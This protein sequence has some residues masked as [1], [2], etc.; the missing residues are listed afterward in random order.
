[1][2]GIAGVVRIVRR[3]E[4]LAGRPSEE[5]I[6]DAWLDAL[7]AGIAWRGPDG[8]GRFRDRAVRSDGSEVH[9]GLV[10]RRLSII[11][12]EGGAQPM[13]VER[14]GESA[15][16]TLVFNGCV[17][18][19]G[20]LRELLETAG[21]AFETSHSDTE[22]LAR[23]MLWYVEGSGTWKEFG[24]RGP[25][26]NGMFAA[27]LWSRRAT[28]VW[29]WRDPFGEKPLFARELGG[30]ATAFA[31]TAGAL[32]CLPKLCDP[33]PGL[34]GE[35]EKLDRRRSAATWLRFGFDAW[36]TP[37][38]GVRSVGSDESETLGSWLAS[39]PEDPSAAA[40][41]LAA[42]GWW[43]V[44]FV[45]FPV[46]W[47]VL[48]V[49][50]CWREA[51]AARGT[52]RS[53]RE[54]S[55]LTEVGA[56]LSRAVERRLEADVPIGCL[57]SGGVDSSLIASYAREHLGEL[58]TVTVRMPD[59]RYDES[60][61][62]RAVAEQI[63]SDHHEIEASADAAT[64]LVDLI[65]KLGLPLGDSSLLPTYWACRGARSVVKAALSG[66]GGDELFWGYDRYRAA[67]LFN[68][69]T[70]LAAR[71][72]PRAVRERGVDDP[73]AASTRRAR[74]LEAA[75]HEGYLDLVSIF[76]TPMLRG[77]TGHRGGWRGRSWI[78]PRDGDSERPRSR[79]QARGWDLRHYLPGDLLLKTDTASLAA[80]LELRAPMLDPDL[81]AWAIEQPRRLLLLGGEPKG[82]LRALARQRLPASV[83]DRPKQGFAI[84]VG[85]WFRTNFGGMRDLL[86][87]L[88]VSP[89][90]AGRPPFGELHELVDFRL[91]YVVRLAD[92]HFAAG[93]MPTVS[94]TARVTPRDHSQRL[95]LLCVLAVWAGRDRAG[96]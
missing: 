57:L 5:V 1:M 74:F 78:A 94:G 90:L 10:H 2:C 46:A 26:P 39:P 38:N 18:N 77:L 21:H 68:P 87:D 44:V 84:P 47:P 59:E 45:F 58:A 7:D 86:M 56:L 27:G 4:E 73:T 8:S 81:A 75:R 63:G 29:L 69:L 37:Y 66:D 92:E 88:V 79:S 19:A 51:G 34:A 25:W 65:G 54:P 33:R 42:V 11:D 16:G 12:H 24:D 6:P 41:T 55:K 70:G 53:G 96:G 67:G 23:S 32:A 61:H 9:V 89:A 13:T 50:H 35:R 3:G 40:D 64:D 43:F 20:E 93:G 48:L 76:P 52:A 22:A 82:L 36:G 62:A 85:D 91:P 28:D 14:P 30:G 80:G 95:Y 49:W 17:Y 15:S 71:L 31:S 83:I 72:L 60:P